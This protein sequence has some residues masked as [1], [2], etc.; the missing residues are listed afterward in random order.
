ICARA[1]ALD[2]AERFA[3]AYD[4]RAALTAYLAKSGPPF[5][6]S[7]LAQFMKAEFA[8]ERAQVHQLISDNLRRDSSPAVSRTLER[9]PG[10]DDVTTVAD[11]ST[12][13]ESISSKSVP[14]VLPKVTNPKH[15]L[16]K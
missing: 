15:T 16:L 13:I 11:L 12:L 14:L 5:E 9:T 6:A 4:F 8:S 1:L 10:H 3:T 2:P 7:H